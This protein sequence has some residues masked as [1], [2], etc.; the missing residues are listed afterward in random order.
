LWR[1]QQCKEECR[2]E[3]P[4]EVAR[5]LPQIPTKLSVPG[6]F[7]ARQISGLGHFHAR[8]PAAN[9]LRGNWPPSELAVSTRRPAANFS[10]GKQA[11]ARTHRLGDEFE[12]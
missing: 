7:H 1:L 10:Q 5:L 8:Q 11:A 2:R 12:Q 4:F 3:D 6:H 9:F